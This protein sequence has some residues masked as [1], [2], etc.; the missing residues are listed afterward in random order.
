MSF[1]LIIIKLIPLPIE[2]SFYLCMLYIP[3]PAHILPM[4]SFIN[5]YA[6][7]MNEE[8][9][10]TEMQSKSTPSNKGSHSKS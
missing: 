3:R 2:S 5:L 9:L 7:T 8:D 10:V 6:V 1:T 4:T